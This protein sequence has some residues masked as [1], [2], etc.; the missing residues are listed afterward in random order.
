MDKWID[1]LS[2]QQMRALASQ[3]RIDNPLTDPIAVIDQKLR[4]SEKAA[5]IYDEHYG[6]PT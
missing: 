2:E 3:C 6:Q 1:S 5:N 4:K